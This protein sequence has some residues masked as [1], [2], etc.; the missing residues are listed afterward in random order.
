MYLHVTS[1]RLAVLLFG[2]EMSRK[3]RQRIG[4]W[5]DPEINNRF[6]AI[7]PHGMKSEVIRALMET[8][9]IALEKHG[10]P[11]IGYVLTRKIKLVIS[12]EGDESGST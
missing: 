5:I 6:D 3:L 8:I 1:R 2:G 4:V 12:T 11:L 9:T 7:V 10:E